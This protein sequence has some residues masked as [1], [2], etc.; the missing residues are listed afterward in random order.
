MTKAWEKRVAEGRQHHGLGSTDYLPGNVQHLVSPIVGHLRLMQAD[1]ESL[2][3]EDMEWMIDRLSFV[4]EIAQEA[5]DGR[6]N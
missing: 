4:L 5:D 6:I 1:G 3:P 2:G